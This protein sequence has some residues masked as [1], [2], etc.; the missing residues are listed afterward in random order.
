[1]QSRPAVKRFAW[2]SRA[3]TLL[4]WLI[5]AVVSGLSPQPARGIV[6]ITNTLTIS[7]NNSVAAGTAVTL[8]ATVLAGGSPVTRGL[9]VFCDANATYC[10]DAAIFGTAQLTANGSATFKLVPGVGD[11]SIKAVFEGITSASQPLTVSGNASYLSATTIAAS[12]SAGNYTLTGTVTGFGREAPSGTVSFLDTSNNNFAVGSATLDLASLVSKVVP[13]SGSATGVGTQP[14][15]IAAGDFNNDGIVD[16]AVTNSGESTISVLMGKG[17]GTFQTQAKFA[18]GRAPD[19]I[20][21]GDFNGDGNLDIVVANRNDNTVSVLLGNGD[22][23]FQAQ[24]TYATGNSPV[25]IAVADFNLD[26]NADIVVANATD[27]T[28]S[29]FL[30]NGDGTFQP[31]VASPAGSLPY[32]IALGDFNR[33][34]IIDAAVADSLD[35]SL[36]VL[37]GNGDGTFQAPVPLPVGNSPFYALAVDLNGDGIADLAAANYKDNTISVLLGNG[38]GTFQNQVTYAA[39]SGAYILSSGDFNADGKA[40]LAVTNFSDSTISVYL[41]NGD[42]TLQPQAIYAVGRGGSGVVAGDFNGDGLTDL[43][44]AN[45]TDGTASVLLAGLR[46]TATAS[47]VSVIGIGTHN[48]LASYPGDTIRAASQ[49]STVPLAGVQTITSTTLKASPNPATK[50]QTVTLTAT[51]A[52]TPTGSPTGTVSFYNGATLLGTTAV[53]SSGIATFATGSLPAGSDTL[54]AVY[55]GNVMFASSTSSALAITI[56]AAPTFTVTAPQTPVT[57]SPGD[58]ARVT[59]TVSPVGGSYSGVVTMSA[60]GLP[61]GTTASFNPAT[62]IP[63]STG[64]S[65]VMTIQ[66]ASQTSSLPARRESPLLLA[67]ISFAVGLSL[68]GTKRKPVRKRLFLL[69]VFALFAGGT[70]TMTACQGLGSAKPQGR[71]YAITVSGS[72][73]MLRS[74][75]TVTLVVQ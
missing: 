24:T 22:G 18:T 63:G 7:P 12:G 46:E 39:G 21:V 35:N 56:Q 42:G 50:G 34:G 68:I 51:I 69:V 59:V 70:L 43:A 71:T 33:D 19:A 2:T 26:G 25:G 29:V 16:L 30:G 27:N 47:G 31:G 4:A 65:T 72:N 17:N 73:G 28:V 41:G 38:D 14:D 62:V 49:S 55:S 64:Q 48:V 11:Y 9:V 13:A 45:F 36:S 66:S 61:S 74:S 8:A 75:T 5:L 53:N 40:D 54:T 1:M 3:R 6:R 57:V 60:S 15:L 32:G 10:E 52:P 58:S 37:L 44:T 20:A 67:S 23:T